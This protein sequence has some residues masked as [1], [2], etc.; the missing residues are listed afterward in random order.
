MG[1]FLTGVTRCGVSSC[2]PESVPTQTLPSRS[3][4]S[5]YTRIAGDAALYRDHVNVRVFHSIATTNA[6]QS[7]SLSSN[8]EISATVMKQFDAPASK[9]LLS[10]MRSSEPRDSEPFVEVAHPYR[11]SCVL[12]ETLPDIARER[13]DVNLLEAVGSRSLSENAVHRRHPQAF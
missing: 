4:S 6:P 5:E 8:P 12:G 13:D 10:T 9:R 11:A 3:S 1:R 7:L 2:R